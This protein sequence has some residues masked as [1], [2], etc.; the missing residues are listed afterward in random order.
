VC[1]RIRVLQRPAS[2]VRVNL[3]HWRREGQESEINKVI[4]LTVRRK[5][6]IILCQIDTCGPCEDQ[7]RR[8]VVIVYGSRHPMPKRTG[9]IGVAMIRKRRKTS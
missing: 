8:V 1:E 6:I 9:D 2:Y 4:M 5:C 7:T 3:G